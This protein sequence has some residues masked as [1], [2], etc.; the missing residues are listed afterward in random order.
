MIRW[1]DEAQADFTGQIAWIA[2]RNPV[3]AERVAEEVLARVGLLETFPHSGRP[4]RR[5]GTRELVMVPRPYVVIYKVL[6]AEI[7]VLRFLHGAQRWPPAK[8]GADEK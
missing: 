7:V 3:A 2:E 6:E 8:E 4:G 1:T 5:E